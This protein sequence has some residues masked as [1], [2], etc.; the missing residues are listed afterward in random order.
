MC[1]II[2]QRGEVDSSWKYF[3][4]VSCP[5][6]NNHSWSKKKPQTKNTLVQATVGR[7]RRKIG[8]VSDIECVVGKGGF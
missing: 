3:H 7:S 1:P 5:V 6:P 2:Q 4:V 8:G